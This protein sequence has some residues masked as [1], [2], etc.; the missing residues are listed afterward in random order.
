M[1][2]LATR[3][4]IHEHTLSLTPLH[5]Y[6]HVDAFALIIEYGPNYKEYSE[7]H[8]GK[9]RPHKRAQNKL[10]DT[11][12]NSNDLYIETYL[13]ML[14]IIT[15]VACCYQEPTIWVSSTV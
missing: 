2:T 6:S 14:P 10:L 5:T 11:H 15:P 3:A 13:F 4:H 7:Q 1:N 9:V 12:M 8:G